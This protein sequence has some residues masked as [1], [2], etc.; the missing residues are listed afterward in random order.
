MMKKFILLFILSLSV[1]CSNNIPNKQN[2]DNHKESISNENLTKVSLEIE[3]MRCANGCAANIEKKL[4]QTQG[5]QSAK[6]DFES[7][8]AVISYDKEQVTES[9][10]ISI[11]EG[12][13]GGDAY[14]V[15]K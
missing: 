6:V 11:I 2:A 14:K 9:T 1:G 8:Q 15:L 3:G 5:V 10:L 12:M 4:S 13:N 7:K